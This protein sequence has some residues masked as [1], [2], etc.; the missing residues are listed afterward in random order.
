MWYLNPKNILLMIL[1]IAVVGIGMTY[2]FQRVAIT[3]LEGENKQLISDNLIQV[4]TISGLNRNLKSIEQH[5]QRIQIIQNNAQ[6]ARE[7]VKQIKSDI[8]LGGSNASQ[9]DQQKI[10][11]AIAAA[12][13]LFNTGMYSPSGSDTSNK[14]N[15]PTT[16]TTNIDNAN[17]GAPENGR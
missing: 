17:Q 11:D 16:S 14:E 6:L 8:Q 10:Q 1:S 9:E 5:Q 13:I 15:M 2:L 7:V 3:D 4:T 12:I